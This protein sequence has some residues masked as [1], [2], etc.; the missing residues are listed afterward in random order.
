MAKSTE[1]LLDRVRKLL[2][3]AESPNVHE[4]A[5]AAARAQAL[6]AR[7]RLQG[8]L[9]AEDSLDITDGGEEPL[10]VSRRMRRWK[11]VLATG[12]A[13]LNGCVAYTAARG[14]HTHLLVAGRPA[15]R[16][17]VVAV[18]SW[19]IKRL[20]WLSATHGA[21]QSKKWHDAF[22]IGAAET[23]LARLSAV[24][25]EARDAVGEAAMVVIGPAL[26]SRRAAVDRY[27][28][29][30]LGLK[31]GRRVMVDVAAF[32]AGQRAGRDVPLAEG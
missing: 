21:G 17:A 14:R 5:Q 9:D 4:A 15:D 24:E 18:W 16:A 31:P 19:L 11:T 32:E 8:L 26:A 25:A 12:L 10:E 28:Q 22:R 20:E 7:H 23:V 30:R 1:A 2:A 3:L 13:D 6:I 29:E 27:A